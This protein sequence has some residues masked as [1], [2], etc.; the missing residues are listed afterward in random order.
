MMQKSGFR[1]YH[2]V[3]PIVPNIPPTL[4]HQS[5]RDPAANVDTRNESNQR[6]LT[7]PPHFERQAKL[8][9]RHS[10]IVIHGEYSVVVRV[11]VQRLEAIVQTIR[12]M[13]DKSNLH[14]A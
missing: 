6:V 11:T 5:P 1:Q 10:D 14:I 4:I 13:H 7:I 12:L 3:R 2:A 9:A 8:L